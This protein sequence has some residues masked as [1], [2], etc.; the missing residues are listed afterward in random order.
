MN[1]THAMQALALTA[2]TTMLA[3]LLSGCAAGSA[4]TLCDQTSIRNLGIVAGQTSNQPATILSPAATEILARSSHSNGVAT[5]VV[6]SGTPE[7][8][9]SALL[10]S[11][12]HDDVVCTGQQ[13]AAVQQVI[14]YVNSLKA[15]TPEVN[16][17][18]AIA[19]AARG[20]GPHSLG[21]L[22]SG[23]GL[24]TVDPLNFAAIEGLLYADPA[25]VAS[26]LRA[27]SLL[28]HELTGV[29]VYWSGFGDV[30]GNQTALTIPARS[31]LVAIWSAVIKASGGSLVMLPDVA[32]GHPGTKLPSV[33]TVA[34]R[35]ELTKSDWTKPIVLRE[36]DLRFVRNTSTFVDPTAA[37]QTLSEIAQSVLTNNQVVTITGTA[38]RDTAHDNTADTALSLARATAVKGALTALKVPSQLLVVAGV[39]H[40]WCGFQKETD[41]SG[42]YSDAIAANNRAVILTSPGV[43]LCTQ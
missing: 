18:D 36:S 13:D 17:L 15:K 8:M 28:P 19:D 4:S 22:V 26:D 40:S 1:A 24:Q 9:G 39:G 5:I 23:S 6:P 27:R 14:D 30:S 21:V 12:A 35:P 16:F 32:T 38:S 10:G 37:Q 33:T 20:A 43:P 25:A 11:R 31:N 2:F 29:T 42:N 41:A 7:R 34:I 3:G